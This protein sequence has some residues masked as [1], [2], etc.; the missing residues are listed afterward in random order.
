MATLRAIGFSAE[1]VAIAVML[2]ALVLALVGA[3]IGV[4]VSY[5][6]F[7]GAAI[8]TLG[9]AHFDA[10]LVYALSITPTLVISVMLLA[11]ALGLAGALVPAIRAARSNIADTLHET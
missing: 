5:A 1:A 2:E 6:F 10:Q 7:D 8:S 11:C 4:G 9:G 3:V